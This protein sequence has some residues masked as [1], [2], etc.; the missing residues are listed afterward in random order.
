MGGPPVQNPCAVVGVASAVV[1]ALNGGSF[2]RS[3]TAER[4]ALPE[5][6]LT[7]MGVLHVTV[8]AREMEISILDRAQDAHDI[9][10]DVAVQQ[11]LAATDNDQVDPLLNLVEEI[12]DYLNRSTMSEASWIKTENVPIYSPEQLRELRQFTSVLRFTYRKTRRP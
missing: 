3:F 11:R 6:E 2:S 1:T 5:F 4:V 9:T 8:V 12:A 10:V 7:D